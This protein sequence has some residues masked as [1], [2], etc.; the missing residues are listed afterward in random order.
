M[1]NFF[2]TVIILFFNLNLIAQ[3]DTLITYFSDGKIESKVCYKNKVRNG[4]AWIYY[5]NGNLKQEL[6]Y[7]NGKVSGLV[8]NYTAAGILYEMFV[9]EA[10]KREGPTSYFDSLG[11]YQKD[12]M[13]VEGRM[14]QEPL[15]PEKENVKLEELA[16][17][18]NIETKKVVKKNSSVE[19]LVPLEMNDELEDDPAYYLTAEIMP[20]PVGGMKKLQNKVL[21]PDDARENEIEGVVKIKTFIDKNGDVTSAEVVE[22]IGY[23]CDD[24]ARTIVYYAKFKPGLQRGRPI[25]VQMII[26]IEFKLKDD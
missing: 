7:I 17:N 20:E 26:P 6:N 14:V 8:K 3:Q 12:V 11:V 1:E 21:Y 23:G 16:S 15:F 10:G 2:L 18:E 13:Y 22:G 4:S 5:D 9:V 24:A 19:E 25:N